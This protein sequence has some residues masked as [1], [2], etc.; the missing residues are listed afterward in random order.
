MERR[1]NE[2]TKKQVAQLG[3]SRQ[4][5]RQ[6]RQAGRQ[7]AGA[8]RSVVVRRGLRLCVLRCVDLI[9]RGSEELDDVLNRVL[10]RSIVDC[11]ERPVNQLVERRRPRD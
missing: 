4:P 11:P 5:V 3:S 1:K 9:P 8:L 10:H 7:K 6:A 2:E